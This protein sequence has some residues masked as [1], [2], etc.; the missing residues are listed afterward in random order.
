MSIKYLR[1]LGNILSG[2]NVIWSA[3]DIYIKSSVY[4]W[5][6]KSYGLDELSMG[7]DKDIWM[8]EEKKGMER[9]ENKAVWEKNDYSDVL[10]ESSIR[11]L[12]WKHYQGEM[13][14]LGPCEMRIRNWSSRF[15]NTHVSFDG[16]GEI[17]IG[18][19]SENTEIG[20]SVIVIQKK[21]GRGVIVLL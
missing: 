17:L 1:T 16:K 10:W 6:V 15:N 11:V 21:F 3:R 12:K 5:H 7:A 20:K 13:L 4:W 18:E 2:V 9:L 14:V 19:R 8:W